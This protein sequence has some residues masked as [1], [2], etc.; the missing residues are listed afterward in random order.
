M[1]SKSPESNASGETLEWLDAD[2]V[3]TLGFFEELIAY[4]NQLPYDITVPM[5]KYFG[6]I[7]VEPYVRHYDDKDGFQLRLQF[8]HLLEDDVII[9][10][11]RIRLLHTNSGQGKDIWLESEDPIHLRKGFIKTWLSSNVRF[12]YPK[13]SRSLSSLTPLG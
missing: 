11:V 9:Q 7:S 8:R 6:D 13:R 12:H 5:S 3:N 4:S 10:K 2:R 1:Q